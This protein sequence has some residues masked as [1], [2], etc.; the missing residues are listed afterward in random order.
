MMYLSVIVDTVVKPSKP[1]ANFAVAADGLTVT[2]QNHASGESGWWDFGDGT[3]LE[4]FDAGQ[5]TVA[6]TYPK[7]GT[8]TVKLT[9]RNFLVEENTR[10]VPVDLSAAAPQT[11]AAEHHRLA[12]RAGRRR[13]RSPRPRSGSAAT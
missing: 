11:P 3:P 4:P 6:H 13:R 5:P 1:V 2:C 12:G 8:Y 7:P 10:A 9:V